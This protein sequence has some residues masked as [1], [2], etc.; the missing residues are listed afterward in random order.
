MQDEGRSEKRYE[1]NRKEA[2]LYLQR[3]W[4]QQVSAGTLAAYASRGGGPDFRKVAGK[5]AMYAKP[6]LDTWALSR[7]TQK[8]PSKTARAIP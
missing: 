3:Q 2:S 7:Y 8:P 6:D 5:W 4:H 1:M